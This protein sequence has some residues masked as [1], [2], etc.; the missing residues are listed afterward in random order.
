MTAE[1]ALKISDFLRDAQ[2][3][4]AD[5]TWKMIVLRDAGD[6]TYQDYYLQRKALYD[7]MKICNDKYTFFYDDTTTF[8]QATGLTQRFPDWTDR[9]VIDE[10]EYLRF[11][12]QLETLPFFVFVGYYPTILAEIPSS[13][14]GPGSGWTPPDGNFLQTL[15][16]DAGG[17]LI[18]VDWPDYLGMVT[19]DINS[20][21]LGR[22]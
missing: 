18:V 7:F 14:F 2:A 12:G 5:L 8:L 6:P 21:F 9:E 1:V 15:R 4:V 11:F 3:K 10:I 13:G 19:R 16:Y 20:Y 22:T 17:N